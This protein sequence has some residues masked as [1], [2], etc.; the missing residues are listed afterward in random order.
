MRL[1][2]CRTVI[3]ALAVVAA[4]HAGPS[5][6]QTFDGGRPGRTVGGGR[7]GSGGLATG[8]LIGAGIIGGGLLM[9]AATRR[10]P[11]AIDAPPGD[12][13]GPI[14]PVRRRFVPPSPHGARVRSVQRTL[15]PR[16]GFTI[17][18]ADERRYV[19]GEIL[20]SIKGQVA[21]ARLRRLE[22]R[23]GLALLASTHIAL[24]DLDVRR[25]RIGRGQN[26]P[27]A[28]GAMRG[29]PQF[30]AAIEPNF[31]Y[32]LQED[33]QAQPPAEP[34]PVSLGEPASDKP[35]QYA[36]AALRLDAAHKISAGA[37]VLVAVIDTG[38]DETNPEIEG[39]VADRFDAVGGE[40]VPLSH[41][42]AMAGV[43]VAHKALTG[44]A[45]QARLL[46]IRAFTNQNNGPNGTGYDILRGLDFAASHG[47]RIVN[48]SFAGPEDALLRDALT[49][50]RKQGIVEV[51]AA[52]NVGPNSK[53]LYPAA[54]SGVIAV[55]ATDASDKIFARANRGAYVSVAAP[56]D[57]VI[58]PGLGRAVQFTSGT[59]VA[60][61]EV[62]GVVALLLQGNEKASPDAIRKILGE[63]ARALAADQTGVGAGLVDAAA[64]VG[65]APK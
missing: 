18:A 11:Q 37:N 20:V 10:P 38:L 25:Y 62:S 23:Y 59:S 64:A 58:A 12:P 48:M 24:L 60:A 55:T 57:N 22:T 41:G 6:A 52:G 43:I 30:V 63:T 50:A 1:R 40:F 53:P 65:V 14:R 27:G 17:P 56:G 9:G 61:A 29:A 36:V 8:V 47:A 5:V 28:I 39:A 33:K 46:A 54:Q 45:P 31:V 4:S 2:A 49:A 16:P 21:P 26:V 3:V 15:P 35:P 51:A 42:T 7:G 32:E 19:T 13:N 44:V 34:I